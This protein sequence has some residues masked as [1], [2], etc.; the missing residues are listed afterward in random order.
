M[1]TTQILHAPGAKTSCNQASCEVISE[2]I[3]KHPLQC[4]PASQSNPSNLVKLAA[5]LCKV[6]R[7]CAVIPKDKQN[8]QQHYQYAS[9]DAV[10]EKVN[11]ALC[12]AG[13]ATVCSMEIL[14]RQLRTTSSGSVWEL[15]T[16]RA[17]ITIIDSETGASIQSEGIG[18][19]YDGADKCISKAQTQA[20]KYAWLLALNIST[21]EDPEADGRSD[22]AQVLPVPCRKC[23]GPAAY[24]DD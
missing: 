5:K 9:S 19:G 17:R 7:A 24:I 18:Q 23:K 13:L 10:L 11:P 4:D 2:P 1:P 8:P 16:V 20:K 22:A 3:G 12:D 6:M 21:G 14:D 15:C